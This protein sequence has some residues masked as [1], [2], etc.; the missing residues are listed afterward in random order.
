MKVETRDRHMSPQV[1]HQSVQMVGHQV[2]SH[3]L[4]NS[5]GEIATA[6]GTIGNRFNWSAIGFQLAVPSPSIHFPPC[7]PHLVQACAIPVPKGPD[8]FKNPVGTVPER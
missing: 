7:T 5:R 6:P 2:A 4:G 1:F 8:T 3:V